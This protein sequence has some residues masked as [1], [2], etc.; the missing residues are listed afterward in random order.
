MSEG[1]QTNEPITVDRDGISV[2]KS[3]VVDEF[4]VPTIELVLHSSRETAATVLVREYVPDGYSLESI[5]FHADYE[6]EHWTAYQDNR[7]EF[8]RTVEPE[9]TVRTIYGLRITDDTE[10]QEFLGDP[11]IVSVQEF[12]DSP[13]TGKVGE[14]FDPDRNDALRS[15][16]SSPDE[17]SGEPDPE[18]PET[19][20][21][22][23][24]TDT[25]TAESSPP[26]TEGLV[27][28]ALAEELASEEVSAEIREILS[29]ELGLDLSNSTE[30]QLR[31]LQTRTEDLFAYTEPVVAFLDDDGPDR[32]K[33]LEVTVLELDESVEQLTSR[34]D[35]LADD[36][37]SVDVDLAGEFGTLEGEVES[38]STQLESISGTADQLDDLEEELAA[39]ATQLESASDSIDELTAWRD[40]LGEMFQGSD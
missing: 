19:A 12:M 17:Q 5:G 34:V 11:E 23:E 13:A 8:E 6:S 35:Q 37:D 33:E 24:P 25:T 3:L 29:T 26:V 1:N 9:E 4:P 28:E 18:A 20:E 7:I 32:L 16:I 39:L 27:A 10:V 40:Q 31:H 22:I 21:S 30:A 14:L 15:L 38:L 2:T 36:L